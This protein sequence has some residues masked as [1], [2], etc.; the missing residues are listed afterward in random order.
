MEAS[1]LP[2]DNGLT[3]LCDHPYTDDTE[4]AAQGF[5]DYV[6][7]DMDAKFKSKRQSAQPNV[8]TTA[9]TPN[10]GKVS[11]DDHESIIFRWY[12]RSS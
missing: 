3:R 5:M 8:K 12:R 9:Y 10:M 7:K 6:A 4:T 1:S 11:I 2:T